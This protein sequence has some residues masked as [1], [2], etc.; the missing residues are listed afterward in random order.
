MMKITS[1]LL[2]FVV[3]SASMMALVEMSA[4]N[5]VEGLAV[6]GEVVTYVPHAPI[7]IDSN[8]DFPGIASSGNGS[9]GSPWIIENWDINGTGVGYC[10][11]V[12]NTTDYFVVRECFLH[13][14]NGVDSFPYYP[15]TGLSLYNVQNSTIVNNTASS[16]NKY[17]IYLDVSSNNIVVNNTVAS[18]NW[19]GIGLFLASDNLVANNKAATANYHGIYVYSSSNNN[20]IDNNVSGN[21]FGISLSFSNDNTIASNIA[22]NNNYGIFVEFSDANTLTNNTVSSSN[23][24]GIYLASSNNNLFYHNSIINNTE[25]AYDDGANFWD[26]GYPDG[27]NYWDDNKIDYIETKIA[28]NYGN[29]TFCMYP[30]I[31]PITTDNFIDYVNADFYTDLLFHRVIDDFVIQGGGFYRDSGNLTEEPVLYP[32]IPL[33]ISPELRHTDGAVGMARLTDPDSATCQFYICDG[34]QPFLDDQ[35]AVFGH[36]ISGMDVV[37][38]IASLPTHAEGIHADVPDDDVIILSITFLNETN[39]DQYNGPS[40]DIPGSDGIGDIP[41]TNIDGGSG[42]QDNYPLMEPWELPSTGPVHNIDKDTYHPT[43]QDGVDDADSGN[44]I[45]VPNGTY[46]E[47]VVIDIPLNLVGEGRNITFIDGNFA[48]DVISINSDWVNIS[49]FTI[50]GSGDLFCDAGISLANARF[51][52]VFDNI[53]TQNNNGIFIRNSGNNTVSSNTCTINRCGINIL[54]STYNYIIENMVVDNT[55]FSRDFLFDDDVASPFSGQPEDL[56]R[57][58]TGPA[59]PGD[60]DDGFVE[61]ALF[62]Y[63]VIMPDVPTYIWQHGC[64][65]TASGMMVGYWNE[66]GFDELVIGKAFSQTTEVDN[67]IASPGNYDDYCLPIDYF[68]D[69]FSDKSEPPEGDEH[70]D[71]SIADFMYT[72]QSAFSNRYGWSWYDDNPAAFEGYVNYIAPNYEVEVRNEVF[73]AFT[74]EDFTEK[75]DNGYPVGFL[76]DTDANGG[77]DHFVTATGYGEM[78][79]G[80]KMYNCHNTW[81]NLKEHWFE[82]EFIEPGQPWGI[83]GVTT[84][85]ILL[86]GYG[87]HIDSSLDNFIF[88]NNIVNNTVQAHDELGNIWDDGY[89]SGGNYWSDYNGADIFSGTEQDQP[90]SDYI[91][92]SP[93]LFSETGA[94]M[95]IEVIN[96]TVYTALG[97]ESGPLYLSHF[98]V[99]DCTLYVDI[100]GEWIPLEESPD[101]TLDYMTGEIDITQISPL[102]AGWIFYAY[103]NYTETTSTVT[104][105]VINETVY[106]A[107]GGESG[108][109]YLANIPVL[110]CTLYVDV[111]GEWIPLEESPD[112]TLDYM[113]GEIDI[114]Q[115]SPLEAGW[116]F[117]AYYNYTYETVVFMGEDNYP[118]MGPWGTPPPSTYEIALSPGWNLISFPLEPV[119]TTISAVLSSIAGKYDAVKYY[120][121]TDANDPWKTYR[122]GASTNDLS[123]IDNTMGL[124][125]NML[126]SANLTVEGDEPASTNIPLYAGWNLVSYPSLTP[127]IVANALWGTGADHVEVFDPAE[128]YLIREVGPDYVMQPGEGYWVH[129]PAD[130]VWIIDW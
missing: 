98:P 91:G 13:D 9:A 64:G 72:S 128:P 94:T 81:D 44:T 49:G 106:T 54:N 83:Y 82:F 43:I 39:L 127:D 80:T 103:Y 93:H 37:M 79:D 73:G 21:F 90:G 78:D 63:K 6:P 114:T 87:L 97:G 41:Y 74:W 92:D 14:A 57:S 118:L 115:I 76:V 125:I 8:A 56:S 126:N 84:L 24:Y 42:A 17:G 2:A 52:N 19:V 32:P 122:V 4:P 18:N 100:E 62:N 111:E 68:P 53:C 96:E 36:V 75:I 108:P 34:A 88:H 33:E 48:G 26:N 46:L 3:V 120:D 105:E 66:M 61:P 129:V 31:V 95:V 70:P 10:I 109:I 16:N 60:V 59:R 30:E 102:E 123:N 25:Q 1:A 15:D 22:F 101:Y 38:A 85:S 50:I 35:Y 99:L 104:V 20:V 40:Q 71:D 107:L 58:S 55:E 110:N 47:N 51:C 28:T 130:T 89:P 119:D 67:M 7:R 69:L 27:G 23:N 5:T 77:T 112:Y 11:Y 124:W 29:I 45:F 113:T 116:I 12:G 121:A 86:D 65:P 117:Y